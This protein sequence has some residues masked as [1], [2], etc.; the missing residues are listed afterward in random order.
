MIPMRL[1]RLSLEAAYS[2][3]WSF[4]PSEPGE[5]DVHDV[6]LTS[7]WDA[8]HEVETGWTGDGGAPSDA[9]HEVEP[10]SPLAEPD[11]EPVCRDLTGMT[12][13][14]TGVTGLPLCESTSQTGFVVATVQML[15]AIHSHN[16]GGQ[17]AVPVVAKAEPFLPMSEAPDEELAGQGPT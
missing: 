14:L 11:V 13:E 4:E 15:V 17:A 8:V 6:A 2:A 3:P 16:S 12:G 1:K 5:D 9:V 10:G 7:G